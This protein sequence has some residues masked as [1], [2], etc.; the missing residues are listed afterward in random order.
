MK[1]V[2]FVLLF[3]MSSL[4]VSDLQA[5]LT[6]AD[7]KQRT[8]IK[9]AIENRVLSPYGIPFHVYAN[10]EM[11]DS[12]RFI[13][14]ANNDLVSRYRLPGLYY[15]RP[16][17]VAD[18]IWVFE[19]APGGGGD[20]YVF[21]PH[22]LALDR[23]IKDE[24]PEKYS[25][26]IRKTVGDVVISGAADQDVDAAVVWDVARDEARTIRLKSG[27]YIGAI[28]VAGDRLRIGACGGV[29]NVWDYPELTFRGQYFSGSRQNVDWEVFNQKECITAVTGLGADVAGAGENSVFIWNQIDAPPVKRIQK[30]MPGS[31]AF[32][33]G[34]YLV[35]YKNMNVAVTDLFSGKIVGTVETDREIEDVIVTK[36][37]ILPD[38][39]GPLLILSL[40]RNKGICFYDFKTLKRLRRLDAGGETLGAHFNAVF[41]TDDRLMYR[42][43]L[44]RWEPE[45]YR[46]F[47]DAVRLDK[48]DLTPDKYSHLVEILADYPDALA[49]TR[50]PEKF[51]ADR[52]VSVS[53][54]FDYGRIP[55]EKPG[56]EPIFGYKSVFEAV[57]QS[58]NH[59]IVAMTAAWSGAFG[60]GN[61]RY[62]EPRR[63][64]APIWF[65]LSPNGGSYSS[66][67]QVG[68]K[69][70]A[71]LVVYPVRMETVSADYRKGLEKA[72]SRDNQDMDLI[73][74]YL[75]DDRIAAWH[76]DLKKRRLELDRDQKGFWLFRIFR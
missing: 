1:A 69:E 23:T 33:Y 36:E 17:R 2:L 35:E 18:R 11:W 60:S 9:T 14:H 32:F 15:S 65:F 4:S 31:I 34:S 50:V 22:T 21:N 72:L 13:L 67:F 70:P 8:Q 54:S 37:P 66:Q 76:D 64:D 41:A 20:I 58:D 10:L 47:M 16:F 28:A 24:A 27:H 30:V 5:D 45:Q 57:N 40:R 71:R 63:L 52:G 74:R 48:I 53:H 61:D 6:D 29:V 55:S 75:E 68:E 62:A 59:Y 26:T 46:A 3:F 43:E 25:G 38:Q 44:T 56:A 49:Q 12:I 73:D 42:F 19:N 7:V 51:M 39:T